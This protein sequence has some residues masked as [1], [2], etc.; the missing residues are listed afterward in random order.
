[1]S[2]LSGRQRR[3]LRA[4]AHGLRPVV[5]VGA[6]G[7]GD[8]LLRAL[9]QALSDHELVKVRLLEPDDKRALARELAEAAGA[10]LAGLV[11]HT[12]ILYRRHPERP[13]IALAQRLSPR[14]GAR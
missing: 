12:A 3:Q 10:E 4:L 5:H 14:R 2:A 13:R 11:G 8:S 7:I 1:V 9:D 6:G